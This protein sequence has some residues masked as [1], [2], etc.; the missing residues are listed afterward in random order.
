MNSLRYVVGSCSSPEKLNLI[1]KLP[2]VVLNFG[3][4]LEVSFKILKGSRSAVSDAGTFLLEKCAISSLL[5]EGASVVGIA[6]ALFRIIFLAILYF[7]SMDTTYL[8]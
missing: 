3:K 1:S 5:T 8:K 6:L 7:N 2:P 4:D